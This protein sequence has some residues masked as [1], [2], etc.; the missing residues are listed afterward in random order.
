MNEDYALFVAIV[1]SGSLSAAGRRLRISPAMVSK[2]LARLEAR[3]GS[4]LVHRTTRRLVLT[5]VGQGFYEDVRHILEAT[6]LAEARVAG[7]IG[8]PGGPL[9]VA[10][11]TSFG[12]MHIAPYLKDFLDRF[13]RIELSLDLDDGFVDLL[14]ERI[15]VAIRIAAEPTGSLIGHRLAENHRILC[16]APAYLAEHGAP[17]TIEALGDH[18]LLAAVHQLPWR[19]EGP[20]GPIAIEGASAVRTNSSEVAR[21]LT[22]AGLGIALRSTWDVGPAL[23]D[24]ALVRILPDICGATDVAIYAV[25]PRGAENAPNARAFVDHFR[26]IFSPVAPWDR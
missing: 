19:L 2:R 7:R 26:A 1:E 13:P 8:Q 21:E 18:R 23:R 9:R 4:T 5:D 14:G 6:R 3:L 20:G 25:Q 12:R 15:D 16:A 17:E 11:P 22:I 24:G 10:A